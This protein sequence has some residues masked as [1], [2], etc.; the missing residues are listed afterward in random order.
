MTPQLPSELVGL[1]FS[2]L[3]NDYDTLKQCSLVCKDWA[4]H[5]RERL[6]RSWRFAPWNAIL[7]LQQNQISFSFK[8]NYLARLT[9]IVHLRFDIPWTQV[10]S[11]HGRLPHLFSLLPLQGVIKLTLS[12]IEINEISQLSDV[13]GALPAL[14]SLNLVS[15]FAPN[16]IFAYSRVGGMMF[17]GIDVF[18]KLKRIKCQDNVDPTS[19]ITFLTWLASDSGRE[20]F[21][22]LNDISIRNI[23][24]HELPALGNLFRVLGPT[25]SKL[26]VTLGDPID[27]ALIKQHLDLRRN[28]TLRR[29]T[30]RFRSYHRRVSALE[31]SLVLLHS[32]SASLE[33]L[34]I[35][36]DGSMNIKKVSKVDW[37]LMDNA[38]SDPP[39]TRL[40]RITFLL[41]A[42]KN[43]VNQLAVTELRSRLPKISSRGIVQWGDYSPEK[44]AF[45]DK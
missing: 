35:V 37:S 6:F 22:S 27:P 29:I 45:C 18:P 8:L 7:F 10:S 11:R 31:L 23:G 24:Q 9:N 16:P 40:R 19:R 20:S 28:S 41:S 2:D 3:S 32:V 5:A 13:L 33:E 36:F 12:E 30:V 17:R 25:L 39:F 14:E 44:L 43:P 42:P 38:L 15:I 26:S 4:P 34:I 21:P 1:V